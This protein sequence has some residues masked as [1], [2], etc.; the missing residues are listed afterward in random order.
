VALTT[1]MAESRPKA[2]NATEPATMPLPT[3]TDASIAFHPIVTCSRRTAVSADLQPTG[4][5]LTTPESNQL[6]HHVRTA[7][8]PG[9]PAGACS[10]A[11][12]YSNATPDTWT[13]GRAR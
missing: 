11:E 12:P 9:K 4:S 13:V 3:A 8:L 7:R 10:L 6:P 1:S 5:T 2:T